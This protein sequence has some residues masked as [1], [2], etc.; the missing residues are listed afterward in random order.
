MTG[1]SPAQ[2]S[3]LLAKGHR[4]KRRSKYGNR[5]T[6]IDGVTFDSAAEA[7]RWGVLQ[8]LQRAGQIERLER[9]KAFPL[10]TIDPDGQRVTVAKYV[11]DFR[12][13]ERGRMVVEDVKGVRTALF[14]RSKRHFEAQ[15]GIGIRIV[16]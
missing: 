3:A 12:Y 9:Q 11:A 8:L 2:I 1:L 16:K 13:F 4:G 14:N 10:D 7:R 15:Y 6:V 5:K